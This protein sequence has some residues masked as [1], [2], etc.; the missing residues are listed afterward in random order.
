[1][2]VEEFYEQ[3][4]GN[5]QDVLKRFGSMTTAKRFVVKFL[6]DKSFPNLESAMAQRRFDDAFRAAHT[7]KG[8]SIN[9]GFGDLYRIS[10][11]V[12]ELLRDKKAEEAEA[13]LG[14][15]RAEYEKVTALV[16][17]VE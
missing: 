11:E 16:P 7:L 10:S 9:L 13:L 5:G 1:M 14:V 15:L 6:Q 17:S 8:V 12:T 4:G 3:I 2:T